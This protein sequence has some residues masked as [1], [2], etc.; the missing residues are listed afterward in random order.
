MEVKKKYFL[1]VTATCLL[2]FPISITSKTSS[3][4]D[5]NLSVA[6]FTYGTLFLSSWT[7]RLTLDT[8][9]QNKIINILEY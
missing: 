5:T 2:L 1:L 6:P 3:G 4:L 8:R 7:A 9:I